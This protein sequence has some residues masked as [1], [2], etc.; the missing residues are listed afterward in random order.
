MNDVK[1]ILR[2]FILVLL[3]AAAL[4]NTEQRLITHILQNYSKESR[5]VLKQSSPTNVTF[6]IELVQLI[7]VVSLL[8]TFLFDPNR[9]SY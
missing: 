3:F 7:N 2:C 1:L 5:P 6:G 9:E 8:K 4:I